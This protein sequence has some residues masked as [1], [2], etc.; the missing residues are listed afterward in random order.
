MHVN[1][2]G[3]DLQIERTS[4]VAV[5]PVMDASGLDLLYHRITITMICIFNPWATTSF[6]ALQAGGGTALIVPPPLPN[7]NP[8]PNTNPP[9]QRLGE[10][11]MNLEE[12]LMTP[13][14]PLQ[15]WLAQDRVWNVPQ[16]DTFPAAAQPAGA[17]TAMIQGGPGGGTT[18]PVNGAPAAGAAY[19]AACD[20][21]GGPFPRSFRMLQIVGDK[22]A[23]VQWT[24]T[25]HINAHCSSYI[26]SNRWRVTSHT[27]ADWLTTR[28]TE[29]RAV[30]RLDQAF[31]NGWT[32]DQFRKNFALAVPNGFIRKEVNVIA[33]ED[34]RELYYRVV[35]KELALNIPAG[36][37]ALRV[38][39]HITTG[40][41]LPVKTLFGG[42]KNAP[43]LAAAAGAGWLQDVGGRM[44]GWF[45]DVLKIAGGALGGA[46]MGAGN[47]VVPRCIAVVRVWGRPATDRK[48]LASLAINIVADRLS[49]KAVLPGVR[50]FPI[51]A[52]LTTNVSTD[53]QPMAEV[54]IEALTNEVQM[55]KAIWNPQNFIADFQKT[56][57]IVRDGAG[58][59]VLTSD[60]SVVNPAFP[61]DGGTRGQWLGALVTQALKQDCAV[62]A[63]PPAD[64]GGAPTPKVVSLDLQ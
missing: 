42:M 10:A 56:D 2:N 64:P 59:I 26:L 17:G 47:Q 34:G 49:A 22:S 23:I 41:A 44:G 20:P 3:V 16:V 43:V 57:N 9:G 13:Q 39:G 51:S 6:Q 40:A 31:A 15:V 8:I 11:I 18:H 1:Y 63:V 33:T 48:N 53:E 35:D 4:D 46:L 19:Q 50:F 54:Q 38:E 45:G 7:V 24:V 25:F 61:G 37:S 52:F 5:E 12:K 29:G 21:A 32:I 58:K 55:F 60:Q 30:M 14:R 36:S 28:I 62:Q 27:G